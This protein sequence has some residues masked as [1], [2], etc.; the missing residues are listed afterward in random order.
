MIFGYLHAQLILYGKDLLIKDF[1][2][3]SKDE[4]IVFSHFCIENVNLW[5]LSGVQQSV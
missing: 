4:N 5:F 2:K 1:K 3:S